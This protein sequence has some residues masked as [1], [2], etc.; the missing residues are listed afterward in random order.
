MTPRTV[1]GALILMAVVL[2]FGVTGVYAQ[3]R[4][5]KMTFSGSNVATTINLEA[6]TVTDE[7]QV[8][9]TGSLGAF[10]FRELH[11]DKATPP[12]IGGCLGPSFEVRA[13][14]GVF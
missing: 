8:A 5:V 11:A 10:T 1:S 6:D 14:A 13:G 3:E 12:V 7:T 4:R 2:N 9:G